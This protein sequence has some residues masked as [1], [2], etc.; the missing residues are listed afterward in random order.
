MRSAE[1]RRDFAKNVSRRRVRTGAEGFL[2]RR[3]TVKAAAFGAAICRFESYRPNQVSGRGGRARARARIERIGA[4]DRSAG[5]FAH[6]CLTYLNYKK[7][8]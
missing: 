1:S 4:R 3:Q 2:G 8:R 5:W 6:P 7:S